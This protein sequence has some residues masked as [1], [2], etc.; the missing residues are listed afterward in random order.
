MPA[1]PRFRRAG[2]PPR[3]GLSRA[4]AVGA[5]AADAIERRNASTLRIVLGF[6]AVYQPLVLLGAFQAQAGYVPAPAAVVLSAVNTL[7]VVAC[8]LAAR[9]GHFRSAAW[10]FIATTLGMLAYSHLRWGLSVQVGS[11]LTQICPV[12]VAG[13]LLGHRAL[14]ASTAATALVIVMGA[15][16]EAARFFF[17]PIMGRQ[18]FGMALITLIGLLSIAVILDRT[19]A[20]QRESAIALRR[21]ND[22]LAR[23]RDLLQ[24][25]MQEGERSRE[26]L[27]HAQKMEVVGRLASG[28]AHDFNHLLSLV[29][30]YAQRGQRS[31]DPEQM[32][33]ALLGAEAAARRAT[34]VTRRLLDF[35]RHEATQLTV[36][37]ARRALAG[38]ESMLRQLF[39]PGVVLELEAGVAGQAP[40]PVRFDRAQLELIVLTLASNADQ[41]MPGGGRFRLSLHEEPAAKAADAHGWVL[42][43]AADTGTGMDARTLARCFEPFFTTKP[44]GVGTGLGLAV[45][46]NLVEASGGGLEA[47]SAP[48]RGSTFRIRL[49]RCAATG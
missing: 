26:Q 42:I 32:R 8:L 39:H 45:A 29:V 43:E 14:W 40:L 18:V 7:V 12:L 34:A 6:M 2:A 48:G 30:G 47:E 21:R 37:D 41:A 10:V 17:D 36:F 33:Q 23:V 4:P 3:A 25:E 20:A 35:S 44:S 11:Q 9:R 19:V 22:R 38:M 28:V 1:N 27:V 24:L 13:L 5:R 49:P 31:D 15:W 46:R 16:W